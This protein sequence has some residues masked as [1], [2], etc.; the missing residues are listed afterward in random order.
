MKINTDKQHRDAHKATVDHDVALRIIAECVAEKVGVCL[1][2]EGVTWRGYYS[3]RD[4]S[5][6]I[7]TDVVVEIIDDHTGKP[8]TAKI[9]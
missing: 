9:G 7:Y 1:E 4:T 3:K 8:D 2:H 5:T 6:G